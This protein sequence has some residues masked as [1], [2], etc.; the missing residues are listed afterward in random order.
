MYIPLHGTSVQP[1]G[2]EPVWGVIIIL[3]IL[4][5]IPMTLIKYEKVYSHGWSKQESKSTDNYWLFDWLIGVYSQGWAQHP[6]LQQGERTDWLN[7]L[8][9]GDNT[10]IMCPNCTP[11]WYALGERTD[12]CRGRRERNPRPLQGPSPLHCHDQVR[13][14]HHWKR[15]R[16]WCSKPENQMK[17]SETFDLKWCIC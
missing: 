12:W 7:I 17:M 14:S 3:I 2:F 6:N 5:N 15:Q 10:K 16:P 4:K 11:N 1:A 8:P 13:I 9:N